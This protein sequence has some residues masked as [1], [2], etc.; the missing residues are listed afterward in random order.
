MHRPSETGWMKTHDLHMAH[1]LLLEAVYRLQRDCTFRASYGPVVRGTTSSSYNDLVAKER[2]ARTQ[3]SRPLKKKK[4][5]E[6][7][8]CNALSTLYK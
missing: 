2:G 7:Q 6:R 3:E 1:A 4:G 5:C 8:S